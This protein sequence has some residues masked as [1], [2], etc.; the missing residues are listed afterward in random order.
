MANGT[1][2]LESIL[3][4]ADAEYGSTKIPFDGKR[5]ELRNVLRLSKEERQAFQNILPES[6][7]DENGKDTTDGEEFLD[8][9]PEALRILAEDKDAVD[10]LLER[11]GSKNDVLL[12]I[13]KHY[14]EDQKAGKASPSQD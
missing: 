11:V 7:K 4:D 5:V 3:A 6:K 8:A 13:F 9:L 14:M 2:D 10:A 1:F 12:T